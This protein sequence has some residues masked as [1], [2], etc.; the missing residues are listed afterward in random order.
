MKTYRTHYLNEL[1]TKHVDTEVV[2]SGWVANRRDHGG[3]IFIDMRDQ[4]GITQIVF[5]PQET[6]K[7]VFHLAET[8]R[9]EYVI[10]IHGKVRNRLEGTVNKNLETGE[11]EVLIHECEILS[12]SKTPPFEIQNSTEVREDLRLQYRYID[13]RNQKMRKNLEIRAQFTQYVRSWFTERNFL[14]IETP[15]LSASSPEGARDYIVPSR[16]HPGKFFA[17]PQAP[18]QYKQLLMCGGIDKY[19][20]IAPCFRDEDSRA[21]RS[22]GE[23]YQIDVETSFL[24]QE[25]FFQLMEP[26]FIDTAKKF[27]PN[28]TIL[29]TPFP[30]IP[31]RDSM[32]RFGTDKPDLR[33]GLEI[34]DVSDEAKDSGFRVFEQ[35][36][37]V[38]A[39]RIPKSH[40][41]IT[42][43]S[44]DTLTEVA[45]K[46]GAG[47]L[48]WMIIGS[49]SGPVAKNTSDEFQEKLNR[50]TKDHERLFIKDETF[51]DGDMVFFG[52][53]DI[54][55][56]E[57]SL[58]AVRIKIAEDFALANESILAFAWIIDFPFFEWSDTEQK[59]DFGH[60]PFSFPQGGKEALEKE[61]PQDILSY[62]YDIIA[63]GLEISSGAVRN[64]DPEILKTAFAM[65]G[66][67]DEYIQE[68][69]GHMMTAFEYGAPP[70]CGFA[71]GLERMLMLLS[72]EETIR[73]FIAFPKSG[74]C[75]DLLLRAPSAVDEKQLQEL[76]IDISEQE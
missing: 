4:S 21:D 38:R 66:Y 23:F 67:K 29:Q 45:K 54:S 42:R 55:I 36:K 27:A 47:G 3:L 28:K 56:V 7:E 16:V 9:D 48:A 49:E 62:Q 57:K 19:F 14:E 74:K 6:E 71:P 76:G 12:Q 73:S 70:H 60:N 50:K 69:F 58:A 22:P 15:L 37:S 31:Y 25:E 2:L 8:L 32:N 40:G 5:D 17:L 64:T 10:R 35:S 24:N 43:R 1:N 33:Y 18:Q 44:I 65:V 26:F 68:K 20:Q 61:N 46:A 53:G 63:N 59:I 41:E 11:I 30:R 39:L 34:V 51:E 13:L 75:E 72:G 52:A